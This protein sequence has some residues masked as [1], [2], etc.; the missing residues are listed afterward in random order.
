MSFSRVS[1]V[2]FDKTTVKTTIL[3]LK[4]E[5]QTTNK[6]RKAV[7]EKNRETPWLKKK[8]KYQEWR[9]KNK[10]KKKSAVCR[11]RKGGQL[12]SEE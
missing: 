9:K 6:E 4:R 8:K 2:K 12:M 11:R 10:N 5:R 7:K 3:Q 1:E